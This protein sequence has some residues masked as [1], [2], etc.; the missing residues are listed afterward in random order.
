[1]ITTILAIKLLPTNFFFSFHLGQM[2]IFL[3]IYIKLMIWNVDIFKNLYTT[4]NANILS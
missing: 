2:G 3:Y 4:L 1:M